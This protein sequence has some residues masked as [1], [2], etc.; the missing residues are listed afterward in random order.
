VTLLVSVAPAWSQQPPIQQERAAG[1]VNG[2]VTD[3]SGAPIGGATVT[4]ERDAGTSHVELMSDPDGRFS[5]SGPPGAFRVTVSATGFATRAFPA[6]LVAGEVTAL[7]PIRLTLSLGTVNVDVAPSTVAIAEQQIKEQEQQRLFG[8][9]PN[10]RVSYRPDAAPLNPRQKFQ[11]AWK[12]VADP[13]RFA[14]VGV[15]ASIQ[16]IRNDYSEF[17]TG[18]DG[19]A[20]R[21]AALYATVFTATMI[22]NVAL[23]ALFRQDPRYFYR[24][25]GS[26]SS[27]VGYALSRAVVR[28]SDSGRWQ[29]DYSRVLGALASGAIS[30]YYYPAE[31]RNGPGVT[32]GNAALVVGGAAAG[33][34]FQEFFFK[35]VTTGPHTTQ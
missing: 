33:N 35:K 24:G 15:A 29:P 25:T 13:A 21:Y 6:E 5:F 18:A 30:N 4:V 17:G 20:K 14:T 31:H 1:V 10:F 8:V 32:L 16:Q 23:P 2:L 7:P 12:T 19:Y 22:S 28:K 26:T 11:L 34:L 27:R 9:F 3:E